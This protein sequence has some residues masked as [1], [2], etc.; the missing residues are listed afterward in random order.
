MRFA[1]KKHV[2]TQTRAYD[3]T[4]IYS[5]ANGVLRI[6][7]EKIYS[8]VQVCV[9]SKSDNPLSPKSHCGESLAETSVKTLI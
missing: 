2:N 6:V 9:K 3:I 7:N 8:P 4:R 5:L 1:E